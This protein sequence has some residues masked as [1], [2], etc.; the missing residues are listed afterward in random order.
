MDI[1]VIGAGPAGMLAA[2]AIVRNGHEPVIFAPQ[3]KSHISK[4]QCL[5]RQIPGMPV[6]SFTLTLERRGIRA[7][8][9]T[10]L[11]GNPAAQC[12][13]DKAQPGPHNVWPLDEVYDILW[14]RYSDFIQPSGL[15][16]RVQIQDLLESFP[17]VLSSA[18][19]RDLCYGAHTF[20]AQQTQIVAKE[21]VA[22]AQ[23]MTALNGERDSQDP[24]N[25]FYRWTRCRG[26]E[27]WEYATDDWEQFAMGTMLVHKDRGT[28]VP[29][30]KPR[31]NDCDCYQEVDTGY[32]RPQQLH[33]IGRFGRWEQGVLAH[34]AFADT[35]AILAN[36]GL[37]ARYA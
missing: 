18:S 33:R 22:S 2:H 25:D 32:E 6:E 27:V 1:A 7:R 8:Y 29:G 14:D 23:A 15:L 30:L 37:G 20:Q 26:L 31:W 34:Q 11:Y 5:W 10:R 3:K 4:V 35:T 36:L 9:A 17:V 13:W 19:A 28:A 21:T 12:G 24:R 16:S